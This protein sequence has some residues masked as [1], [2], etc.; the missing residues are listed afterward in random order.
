MG[1]VFRERVGKYNDYLHLISSVNNSIS[2][3]TELE[4]QHDMQNCKQSYG[5]RFKPKRTV[6]YA[7][8]CVDVR[9]FLFL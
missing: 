1:F 9:L 2:A 8:T 4:K 6:K 3:V 5:V 7:L